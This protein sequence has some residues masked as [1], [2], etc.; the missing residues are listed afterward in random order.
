[1][2]RLLTFLSLIVF[3]I[4]LG[5]PFAAELLQKKRIK[6]SKS[7]FQK[8]VLSSTKDSSN[9]VKRENN[10]WQELPK[11]IRQS[12]ETLGFYPASLPHGSQQ[13]ELPTLAGAT[14][15]LKEFQ[16]SWVLLNFWATWCPPCRMEMPSLD[17]LQETYQHKNL[18]V[19]TINVQQ[20]P[21]TIRQFNANYGLE[22]TIFR[23]S[24]GRVSKRYGVVGLP[25]TWLLTPSGRPVA[26]ID[27]PLDWHSSSVR[28]SFDKLL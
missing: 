22:L 11:Q 20:Q 18:K 7:N 10:R 25:E 23:D 19:L 17:Q 3:M 6:E 4:L 8:T 5:Y 27:G 21:E 15:S 26:K 28:K 12:F 1:M 16:G 14:T 24:N 2:Q 13:F 9:P